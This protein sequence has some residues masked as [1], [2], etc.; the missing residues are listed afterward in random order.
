MGSTHGRHL[1]M[2]PFAPKHSALACGH[3]LSMGPPRSIALLPP[4]LPSGIFSLWSISLRSFMLLPTSSTLSRWS[5]ALQGFTLLPTGILPKWSYVIVGH[6]MPRSHDF[7][8][9]NCICYI[10]TSLQYS[11]GTSMPLQQALHVA[12]SV[13][14]P[15]SGRR[16]RLMKWPHP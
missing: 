6:Y 15:H 5:L 2:D 7:T 16:A 13:R 14:I 3:F 10:I 9:S 1:A 11:D 12:S 4:R 8:R